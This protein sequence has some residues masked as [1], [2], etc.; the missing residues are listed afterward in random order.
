MKLLVRPVCPPSYLDRYT[1]IR[2]SKHLNTRK[3]LVK[4]HAFVQARFDEL[5]AKMGSQDISGIQVDFRNQTIS[6]EL[7]A[8]YDVSTSALRDLKT[9]IKAAQP[10]RTLKYC[11]MCGTTLHSTFDHY[12]PMARFPEFSVHALNLVPCCSTCN[13]TKL[14]DWLGSN[15]ERQYLHSFVD[16]V[17]HRTPF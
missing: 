11:P 16:D 1:A 7:K 8:C 15:G 6:N 3:K 12:M 4:A 2:D 14:H 13:S 5:T 10:T 9:A 17:S